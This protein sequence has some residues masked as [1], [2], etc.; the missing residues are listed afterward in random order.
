MVVA[1]EDLQGCVD[2]EGEVLTRF[3]LNTC[4]FDNTLIV[5]G[6]NLGVQEEELLVLLGAYHLAIGSNPLLLPTAVK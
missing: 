2:S 3:S 4:L 5:S 1:T 6:S